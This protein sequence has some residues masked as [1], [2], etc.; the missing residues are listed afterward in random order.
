MIALGFLAFKQRNMILLTT[1]ITGIVMV[2]VGLIMGR[3]LPDPITPESIKDFFYMM[4]KQSKKRVIP[5]SQESTNG[6]Q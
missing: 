4:K 1:L 6:I 2:K 5:A 3:T